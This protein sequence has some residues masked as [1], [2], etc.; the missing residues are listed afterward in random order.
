MSALEDLFPMNALDISRTIRHQ[1]QKKLLDMQSNC[2]PAAS[3]GRGFLNRCIRPEV[4][5]IILCTSLYTTRVHRMCREESGCCWEH[6]H[7]YFS[8][9][10]L[11][12]SKGVITSWHGP[13][14]VCATSGKEH[15]HYRENTELNMIGLPPRVGLQGG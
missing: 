8:D 6:L 15:L 3:A 13:F 4:A 11:V 10:S 9:A 5:G 2:T 1:G 12:E 7:E 14:D